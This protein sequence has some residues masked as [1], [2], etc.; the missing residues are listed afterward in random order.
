MGLGIS[1]QKREHTMGK[2]EY[3]ERLLLKLGKRTKGR[4]E[5][6]TG[7]RKIGIRNLRSW[8]L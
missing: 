5:P 6:V 8:S 7:H 2:E 4:S 3:L 1:Q